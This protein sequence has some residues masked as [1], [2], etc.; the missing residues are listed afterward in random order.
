MAEKEYIE[1]RKLI[2]AWER[3]CADATDLRDAFD[4]ALEDVPAA[5]VVEVVRCEKCAWWERCNSTG[6]RGSCQNPKNGI[7]LEYTDNTDFCSYGERKE[8]TP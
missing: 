6:L 1:K 3:E 5:D 8:A 2:E 4:F 7:S